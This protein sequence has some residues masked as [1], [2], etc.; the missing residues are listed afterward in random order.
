MKRLREFLNR[1]FAI[2][3]ETEEEAKDLIYILIKNNITWNNT[4]SLYG[5]TNF[6]V[7][8]DNTCYYIGSCGLIVG[9]KDVVET[10]YQII[11]FKDLKE[12]KVTKNTRGRTKSKK[13]K[14]KIKTLEELLDTEG[15]VMK[16]G[17]MSIKESF[18]IFTKEMRKF[19]GKEFELEGQSG[20]Y[21]LEKY[22]VSKWMC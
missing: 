8:K 4:E 11:K 5:N 16:Y 15:T 14:V 13:V 9:H 7:L 19:C 21:F 17:V 12:N 2:N 10:N 6:S 1:R 3:C 22:N 20:L 18:A